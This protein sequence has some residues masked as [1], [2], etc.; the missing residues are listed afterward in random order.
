ME[1]DFKFSKKIMGGFHL[2]D[3]RWH[4]L[5]L[6]NVYARV[7]FIPSGFEPECN[8]NLCKRLVPSTLGKIARCLSFDVFW[9]EIE[10]RAHSPCRGGRS[11]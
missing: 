7:V 8:N 4:G 6:F 11:Y 2:L 1:I 3:P 9:F 10:R 5:F